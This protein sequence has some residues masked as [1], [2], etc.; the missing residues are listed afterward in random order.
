MIR[1]PSRR[2]RLANV[3]NKFQGEATKVLCIC[4]AGL[5]RSPTAAVL[6]AHKD[7]GYNTRAVGLTDEYALIPLDDALLYWADIIVVMEQHQVQKVKDRAAAYDIDIDILD[8]RCLDIEDNFA[9][10]DELLQSHMHE[11]FVRK[12]L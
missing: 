8:I 10:M 2:N 12:R 3:G 9:Y 11:A 6:L 5:L 7:Y 1:I 4:S